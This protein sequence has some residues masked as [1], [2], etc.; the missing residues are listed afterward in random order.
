MEFPDIHC[1]YC[2]KWLGEHSLELWVTGYRNY[3]IN[4]KNRH[5]CGPECYEKYKKQFEFPYKD[6]VMY[7]AKDEEYIPYM[8]CHYFFKT[9]EDC[10]KR[11]KANHI[12]IPFLS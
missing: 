6:V 3:L 11:M 2:N 10:Y 8:G 5:F 1:N 12:S 7:K 4:G 9:S